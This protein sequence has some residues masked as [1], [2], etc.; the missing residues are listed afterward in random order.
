M[1]RVRTRPINPYIQSLMDEK[2]VGTLKELAAATGI[3]YGTLFQ[4]A[5][6]DGNHKQFEAA[7]RASR[8][9]GKTLDEFVSGILAAS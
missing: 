1:A 5:N 8:A 9:C 6:I 2:G 4:W 3:P 7:L